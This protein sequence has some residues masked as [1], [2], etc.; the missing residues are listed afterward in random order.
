[1]TK[2]ITGI[3]MLACLMACGQREQESNAYMDN[4]YINELAN[5]ADKIVSLSQTDATIASEQALL[6]NEKMCAFVAGLE[7]AGATQDEIQGLID[8]VG[9][10]LGAAFSLMPMSQ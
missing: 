3:T 2:V 8:P 7:A 9:M 5:D 10:R 4:A 1:M 6:L